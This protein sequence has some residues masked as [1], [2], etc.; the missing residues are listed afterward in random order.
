M[1]DMYGNGV[2]RNIK[3]DDR[4]E[5]LM[6]DLKM[7]NSSRWHNI[8]MRQAVEARRIKE[9]RDI[10]AIKAAGS[11]RAFDKE[12]TKALSLSA[13]PSAISRSAIA[14]ATPIQGLSKG[15]SMFRSKPVTSQTT[16]DSEDEISI[17]R[18]GSKQES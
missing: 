18:E 15:L 6:M 1:I 10:Q 2:K 13:S 17:L 3:F 4:S 11:D 8:T 12:K 9:E 14:N 7:P 16:E 5:S